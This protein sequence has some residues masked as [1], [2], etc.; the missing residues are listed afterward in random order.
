MLL[1]GEVSEF[2]RLL[3]DQAYFAAPFSDRLP[4]CRCAAVLECLDL[5]A[6]N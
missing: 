5:M 2:S 1:I 6:S 4:R 3:V